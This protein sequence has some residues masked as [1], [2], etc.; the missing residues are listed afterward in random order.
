MAIEIKITRCGDCPFCETKTTELARQ[1]GKKYAYHVCDAPLFMFNNRSYDELFDLNEIP[2][3]CP[4]AAADGVA[5]QITGELTHV[6]DDEDSE[7]D[8]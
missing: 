1:F 4:V 6:E 2:N 3:W 5:M 8:K 7:D